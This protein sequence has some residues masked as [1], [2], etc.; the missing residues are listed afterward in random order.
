[1]VLSCFSYLVPNTWVTR[2]P[3]LRCVDRL[4]DVPMIVNLEGCATAIYSNC[5]AS[6]RSENKVSMRP[7]TARP[8]DPV[9]GTVW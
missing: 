6:N 5:G 2:I 4:F 7:A 1:V 3:L 8:I 9:I